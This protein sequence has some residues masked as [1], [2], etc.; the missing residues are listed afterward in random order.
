MYEKTKEQ[1]QAF[2]FCVSESVTSIVGLPLEFSPKNK[3]NQKDS[4]TSSTMPI[5]LI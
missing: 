1:H 4:Y 3:L 5:S 2:Y